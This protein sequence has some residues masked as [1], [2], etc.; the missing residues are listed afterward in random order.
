LKQELIVEHQPQRQHV[1]DED[2]KEF[3]YF[4]FH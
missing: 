1:T 2:V 3:I 4:C